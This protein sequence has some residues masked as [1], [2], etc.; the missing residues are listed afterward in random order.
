MLK[1]KPLRWETTSLRTAAGE[2]KATKRAVY[3]IITYTITGER[4]KFEMV[5]LDQENF[6]KVNRIPR[7]HL[8]F[9]SFERLIYP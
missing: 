2:S 5:C 1:L 9:K 7:K 3:E 6:S 4:L 8:R